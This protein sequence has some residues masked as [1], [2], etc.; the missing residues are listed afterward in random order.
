M[1]YISDTLKIWK[2]TVVH[3]I[4]CFAEV[5]KYSNSYLPFFLCFD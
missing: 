1:Q 5:E 3:W 4:E 2:N